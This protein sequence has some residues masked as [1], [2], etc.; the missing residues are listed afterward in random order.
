MRFVA[1]IVAVAALDWASW[2]FP[3]WLADAIHTAAPWVVIAA[4]I[5]A[6][7]TIIWPRRR[8]ALP[9]EEEQS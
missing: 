6:I 4:A 7:L 3:E 5:I 1:I 2:W 8:T 9:P